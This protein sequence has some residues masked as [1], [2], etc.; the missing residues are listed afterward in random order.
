MDWGI[1]VIA[2]N[3]EININEGLDNCGCNFVEGGRCDLFSKDW[4]PY[5]LDNISESSKSYLKNLPH[6]IKFNFSNKSFF[7]LHGGLEN[8]AEYIFKSG[9]DDLKESILSKTQSDF[10]IAGHCGIPFHQKLSNGFWYNAGV[11]GLPANDGKPH[12]WHLSIK[13]KNDQIILNHKS[14]NYD[15]RLSAKLIIEKN[16]PESYAKT[17]NNGIWDNCEIL[18]PSETALQGQEI[19]LT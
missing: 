7:V 3:V 4:Y 18:P 15:H 9:K 11:I 10:I 13:S 17:I 14:F 12:V 5:I 19:T 8:P 6:F 2:G 1:R 16:L